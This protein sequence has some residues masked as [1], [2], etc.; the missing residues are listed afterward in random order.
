M[1]EEHI[2]NLIEKYKL[3]TTTLIEE[4]KLFESDGKTDESIKKIS[5]FIKKTKKQVPEN[6]NENLWDSFEKKTTKPNRFKIS[7]L[8]AAASIALIVS[9]YISNT[10]QNE[11]S[12]SEKEALLNEAKS[13]FAVTNKEETY[14]VLFEDELVVVYTKNK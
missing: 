10:N 7:L 2:K 12:Y 13:M 1:K 3:G 6:F 4:K 8:A 9:L 5:T 11:L 14:Q